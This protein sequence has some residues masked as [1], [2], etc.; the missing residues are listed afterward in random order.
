MREMDTMS[1][2][3]NQPTQ[4]LMYIKSPLSG[5]ASS[6]Y[7]GRNRTTVELNAGG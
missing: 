5:Y 3:P 6:T 7:G 4:M 2:E 1:A